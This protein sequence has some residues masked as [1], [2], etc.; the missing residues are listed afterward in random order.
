MRRNVFSVVDEDSTLT[1]EKLQAAIDAMRSRPTPRPGV[2]WIPES[3]HISFDRT[4]NIV[5]EPSPEQLVA[6]FE[7]QARR[8]YEQTHNIP[9]SKSLSA[10]LARAER[11][12]RR[13]GER[14]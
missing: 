1:R 4:G 3:M 12:R 14:R 6:D 2:I 8:A 7:R 13:K 5:R 10:R 11:K 9:Y